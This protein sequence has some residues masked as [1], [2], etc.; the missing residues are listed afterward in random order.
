M[1]PNRRQLCL[2]SKHF[3]GDDTESM[4]SP[5]RHILP[6]SLRPQT[7]RRALAAAVA[8]IMLRAAFAEIAGV[9]LLADEI[10]QSVTAEVVR[11]LPRRGLVD[12]HQGRMQLECPGHAK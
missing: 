11:E 5:S 7:A 9:R 10:D 12:P 3:A 8:P 6:P 4:A 2:R 1:C